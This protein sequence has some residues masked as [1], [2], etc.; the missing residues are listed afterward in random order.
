MPQRFDSA[1]FCPLEKRL[2]EAGRWYSSQSARG[3]SQLTSRGDADREGRISWP[4]CSGSTQF[5]L[6]LGLLESCRPAPDAAGPRETASSTAGSRICD[7][8]F[9]VLLFIY[10]GGTGPCSRALATLWRSTSSAARSR[11]SRMLPVSCDV[12]E[13]PGARFGPGARSA[14]TSQPPRVR[15]SLFAWGV[16]GSIGSDW[17]RRNE[18]SLF[19]GSAQRPPLVGLERSLR[20]LGRRVPRPPVSIVSPSVLVVLAVFGLVRPWCLRVPLH[21]F[22]PPAS[23]FFLIGTVPL[24]ANAVGRVPKRP[25]FGGPGGASARMDAA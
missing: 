3:L 20:A 18:G 4:G 9:K 16:I 10:V 14:V 25:R 11:F 15:A 21:G 2:V 6:W 23:I 22:L 1:H 12:T 24:H 7:S 13:S 8:R 5:R 17:S 19:A